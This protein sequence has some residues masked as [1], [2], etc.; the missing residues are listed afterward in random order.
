MTMPSP[1][2]PHHR[3]PAPNPARPHR[4]APVS[5]A[6]AL[7]SAAAFATPIAAAAA[8]T[9]SAADRQF[10][11]GLET[12]PGLTVSLFAGRDQAATHLMGAS[13]AHFVL[14]DLRYVTFRHARHFH[15]GEDFI[16]N[17]VGNGRG[18]L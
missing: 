1:V 11:D 16:E 18:T 6:F 3:H 2:S 9:V 8:T 13:L 14:D 12:A 15:V 17:G 5:F 4:P 7:A 10:I